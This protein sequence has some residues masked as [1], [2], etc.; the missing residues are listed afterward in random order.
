MFFII[1]MILLFSLHNLSFII[2][3]CSYFL[4]SIFSNIGNPAIKAVILDS[5]DSPNRKK[6]YIY[7]YGL[8]VNGKICVNIFL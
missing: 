4:F 6:V 3:T 2:F 7:S 1:F 5:T 8:R